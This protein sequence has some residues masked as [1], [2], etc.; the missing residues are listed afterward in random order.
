MPSD[1]YFVPLDHGENPSSAA[2]KMAELWDRSG[3]GRQFKKGAY[4]AVKTHF[5]ES[6]NDTFVHPALVTAIVRKLKQRGAKPFLAETSTLYRGSRSNAVDHLALA[7]DH[8]F[9]YEAVKAPIIMVDGLLGDSEEEIEID[10]KHFKKVNVAR[11]IAR[12]NG[13]VVLSH[14][15]GHLA[16][17]FG[18]AIKNIGMGLSSRRGKLRQHSVMSPAINT[19]RCTACGECI[20]WCPQ[21]TISLV[22]GK[23]VI[24]KENCIGCGECYAVCAFGAVMFDWRRESVPLQEMMAEHAAGVARSVGGNLFYFN[25]LVNI[26]KNCDCMN[27][28]EA[29]SRDIG[30]VA[31]SDLVAVEK[32]S[33]DLFKEVN[34]RSLE[35][36][37][38]PH[39]NSLAQVEHAER[40]GLGSR[41]YR[42]VK[43]G[44]GS[45]GR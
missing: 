36:I 23:A 2:K 15:T 29:L 5:G 22:E 3:A 12:A 43:V 17:G 24:H 13:I 44:L 21:D 30:M 11:E 26:T 4:V 18:A 8:G 28:G 6:D 35:A 33:Y 10:G 19:T 42:L 14:F 7:N 31:G 37:A 45:Q 39:I 25:V 32:A 40:L 1:I 41:D 38:Y 27:G 9:G 20:K 16:S 34:G